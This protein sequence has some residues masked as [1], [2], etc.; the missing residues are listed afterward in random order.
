MSKG[1]I[2]KDGVVLIESKKNQTANGKMRGTG[3]VCASA[4]TLPTLQGESMLMML[5]KEWECEGGG[6]GGI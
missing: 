6:S 2:S 4:A 3:A 1:V 5:V